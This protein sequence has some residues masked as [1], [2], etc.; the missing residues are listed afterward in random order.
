MPS[1]CSYQ[2]VGID[3]YSE[4]ADGLVVK[5]KVHIW[6]ST[7]VRKSALSRPKRAFSKPLAL[8]VLLMAEK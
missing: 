7:N 6:G 8:M 5:F 1:Q 4:Y 3:V 2:L